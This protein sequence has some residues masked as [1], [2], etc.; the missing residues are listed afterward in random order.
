M[1]ERSGAGRNLCL[2]VSDELCEHAVVIF[3]V[4]WDYSH[5]IELAGGGSL[6]QVWPH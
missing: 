5:S 1:F 3:G 2:L 6:F 4:W